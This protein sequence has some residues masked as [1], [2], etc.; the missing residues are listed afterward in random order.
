VVFPKEIVRT[1]LLTN[2]SSVILVHNHPSDDLSPSSNDVIITAAVTKACE[3]MEIALTDHV[4]ISRS[5]YYSFSREG[6]LD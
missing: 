3:I 6:M 5:G 4:I 2:A 1:A